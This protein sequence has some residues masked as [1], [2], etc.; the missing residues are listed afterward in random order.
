MAR[1]S[2]VPYLTER[3]TRPWYV[4]IAR[5]SGYCSPARS[6][7]ELYNSSTDSMRAFHLVTVTVARAAV[8]VREWGCRCRENFY[9]DLLAI[10][11]QRDRGASA[12]G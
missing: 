1:L 4:F 2:D 10:T 7:F 5:A 3:G 11:G 6:P 9:L 8:N 12:A